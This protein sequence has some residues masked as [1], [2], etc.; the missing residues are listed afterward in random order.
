M[1]HQKTT[2]DCQSSCGLLILESNGTDVFRQL[3]R[4][5]EISIQKS[6]PKKISKPWP[7]LIRGARC[8][9]IS[10]CSENFMFILCNFRTI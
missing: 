10:K 1:L 5:R 8:F 4:L 2:L 3:G 7:G 9:V 6:K